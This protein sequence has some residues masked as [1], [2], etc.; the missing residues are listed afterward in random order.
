[1]NRLPKRNELWWIKT[2]TS[3]SVLKIVKDI[4]IR[5]LV[6]LEDYIIQDKYSYIETVCWDKLVNPV[7]ATPTF[8]QRLLGYK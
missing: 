1:M 8:F 5:D 2:S 4:G 6:V 3:T 7:K